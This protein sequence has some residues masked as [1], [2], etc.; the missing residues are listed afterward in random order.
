MSEIKKV[1]RVSVGVPGH[2]KFENCS[3]KLK[4]ASWLQVL[5]Q[6]IICAGNIQ[7]LPSRNTRWTSTCLQTTFCLQ[8]EIILLFAGYMGFPYCEC[9]F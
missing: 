9:Y 5:V 4:G 2:K 7:C 1:I 6:D 8:K 3:P